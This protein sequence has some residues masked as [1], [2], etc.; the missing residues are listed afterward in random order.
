LPPEAAAVV[1]AEAGQEAEAVQAAA[2]VAVRPELR[3]PLLVPAEVLQP[4]E[5]AQEREL[6]ACG[7]ELQ[8]QPRR[9]HLVPR[10]GVQPVPRLRHRRRRHRD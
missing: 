1:V 7:P 4:E 2:L 6:G 9:P 8:R 3:G 10:R 5:V